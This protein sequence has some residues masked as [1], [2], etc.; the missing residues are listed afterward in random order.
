MGKLM[1][2][3]VDVEGCGLC[4][5]AHTT[6]AIHIRLDESALQLL[7]VGSK[8]FSTSS[9]QD[10]TTNLGIGVI[11]TAVGQASAPLRGWNDTDE[12]RITSIG[13]LQSNQDAHL[14]RSAASL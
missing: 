1:V 2:I 5:A 3:K 10:A 13:Y 6:L 9:L 11:A 12:K 14:V 8:A 4:L 7:L